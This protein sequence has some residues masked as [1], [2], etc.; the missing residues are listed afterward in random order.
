MSVPQG[1]AWR[2]A[3]IAL[4]AALSTALP[5]TAG[6]AEAA[7]KVLRYAFE[8]AETGF[9]PAQIS[10]LYSRD[11][12][13]N[14]F[15]APLHFAWLGRAGELTPNTA[16][17]LPEIS[18]DFRTFTFAL[19]PGI[20]FA[21]DP[22]FGGKRR[23]LVAA[24]YVYSIKRIADP[25]W[26]SPTWSAVEE[27][28]IV[29]LKAARDAAT[30][31]GHFDYDGD[32]EG[33]R[34]LDRYR[35]RVTLERPMPHFADNLA[36][37]S[38][39]GAV[40]REVVERYPDAMMEHPVGTG[41]F[42]LAEWRRSSRVVL[43]RN[44]GYRDEP[45]PVAAPDADAASRELARRFAGRRLP[46]IDRVEISPIEES[47]PRW[48]A[49]LNDE[50]DLLERMPRDL[51][52]LAVA[53]AMPTPTLQRRHVQVLR[54][55]EID[56]TILVYNID[57]AAIGG[58]APAQVALR[59]AINLGFN[60]DEVIRSI[61][62]YQAVPAQTLVQPGTALYDATIRTEN[63]DY[64]PVRAN[65]LLDIYGYRRGADGWRTRP[66]GA[67]LALAMMLTPDQQDRQYAEIARKSFDALGLKIDFTF[68]KWPENLRRAQQGE[69]QIWPVALSAAG[70]DSQDVMRLAY[71]GSIGAYDLSRIKLPAY[72]ALY[73][74]A[75]QLPD[76]PAR[77][78]ILR[79]MNE[80]E[81]A[82]AP[83]KAVAHRFKI[84]LAQ[85]W[86]QGYRI[87][88]FVRDWWRYVDVDAAAQARATP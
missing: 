77:A 33:L 61:Y 11:I 45:Y 57:D 10:D 64:D 29:G 51:A 74:Q 3:A 21:D 25:R 6:P 7:P 20:Y 67:P 71:S 84:D 79:R 60:V 47:Q 82:Y 39:F 22:A 23:E 65:A 70:P 26:K 4:S 15:D 88:P 34:V 41:P 59:R 32:V 44:P 81:I 73:L 69:F 55:P 13:A 76:G 12:A 46:M 36:D 43:E 66:D 58:Y 31:S 5:A 87:V 40:A 2:A 86:V 80:L 24:D 30:R 16:A 42:R 75:A 83:M 8:I 50:H 48:L 17:S 54:A 85:P 37:P 62:R 38:L 18:P 9:D 28:A 19:K 63:G 27:A 56:V 53:G 1:R 68:G 49:F 14:I 78:A 72:D 52:T 35:F